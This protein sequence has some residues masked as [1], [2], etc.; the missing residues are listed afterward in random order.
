[1][2]SRNYSLPQIDRSPGLLAGLHQAVDGEVRESVHDRMLYSTDASIYQVEPLGVV[3]PTD[4]TDVARAVSWCGEHRVPMLPRGGGTSLAGQCVNEAVV[5]DLSAHCHA[6]RSIDVANRTAVVEPGLTIDDLND[7]LHAHDLFFAPDPSTARHAN[8]GGCIGNNAAGVHSV[9]YG[10]TSDSVVGIR[11]CLWDGT[12]VSFREGSAATD[13]LADRLATGVADIV[14]RHRA[15]IRER[16][17]KTLRRSAGYQLDVILDQLERNGDDARSLNL[18]PLLCGSE[19]TL[20]MTLEA[21]L[22]LQPIPVARG[23]AVIAFE[24]V[25]AAIDAVLPVLEL[26][27]SAVELLDDL[28]V[29]LARKNHEQRRYIELLPGGSSGRLSAVLYVEFFSNVGSEDIRER[30]TQAKALFSGLPCETITDPSEMENAWKLRKAGEPLLHAIPGKRKPLGFVE[31]NAVPPERLGE[32]VQRFRKIVEDENTIASF[33]AH[34]SVGVL[35]VRPLLDLKD[36]NDV[37]AMHRIAQRAADLAKELGGVMSGEHGDGR[38]RGPLLEDYFGPE[39]MD[40]FREVKA[41]FDPHGLMNPGNIVTPGPLESISA[42][43]R[44]QPGK[45]ELAV[46]V[47]DTAFAFADQGGMLHAAEMCNG[48]GVCRKKQGG[49][50]CPSYQATL[51]ERHATRGR[52][53]AL[54]LAMTGQTGQVAN[55]GQ[56]A[57]WDDPETHETLR[58]CLSCKACKSECPSNVDVARLKAEYLHQSYAGT[59]KRAPFQARVFGSIHRLNR[60]AGAMPGL[61]NAVNACPPM[62][63]VLNL[64]L[65]LDPRRSLPRFEKPI[66]RASYHVQ[67]APMVIVLTDTF[68][69]HNDTAAG[70]AAVRVLRAFGYSVEVVPVSDLGRAAISTGMLDVAIQDAE[71]TLDV[72]KDWIEDSNVAGFV[73]CEP[74]CLSSITDDWLDLKIDRPL[75]L[76]KSLAAKAALPEAFLDALWDQHP[77]RPEF[78]TAPED[79]HVHGHCHQKAL[80]GIGTTTGMLER[81]AP[82]RVHA[83][84]AGC[85]GMAGSFGYT[86]DRYDLSMKIGEMGVFPAARSARDQDWL[87]MPGTSCRHQTLDGTGRHAI[88]PIEAV[89]RLLKR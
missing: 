53:N 2:H 44:V 72:L 79:M 21:E 20:A 67:G 14:R 9:L 87:V 70:R 17:P 13:P 11:A 89:D 24:S 71:R 39:L 64:L 29:D 65:G 68:T 30:L 38:A 19:G 85:C 37:A 31:D 47:L 83:I 3:I 15:L 27:P 28:I 6:V 36:P 61:T 80:W 51:D 1:M 7:R 69:T 32:F 46:P 84:D 48:A 22:R 40:A 59:G 34:A 57:D 76:R 81:I 49:T 52:G 86:A 54:R 74:S 55:T 23:L 4:V 50:M 16:F 8:I 33:Y 66:R 78:V 18:A 10:R 75:E 12:S 26:K 42:K 63:S 88:H 41:L 82:G 73:V 56:G 60:L 45:I 43:T 58:L 35:H 25:E 62:R 5:F 77:T